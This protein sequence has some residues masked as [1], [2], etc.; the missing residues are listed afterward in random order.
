MAN[1]PAAENQEVSG[2]LT[3]EGLEPGSPQ[4]E[5]KMNLIREEEERKKNAVVVDEWIEHHIDKN[6]SKG[7]K[8]LLKKRL[9]GQKLGK[10]YL[11]GSVHTYYLGRY[12]R[13]G[14]EAIE[15]YAKKGVTVRQPKL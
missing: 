2:K 11:P 4:Y 8:V 15:A 7:G 1:Q 3:L 9:R 6:H 14:K 10:S 12:H 13:G 5:H